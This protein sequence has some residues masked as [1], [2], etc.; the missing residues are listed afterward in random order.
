M[1]L[2]RRRFLHLAGCAAAIPAVS[3]IAMARTYPTRPVHLI[4]GFFAG[5]L[6][7]ILARLIAQSL[8]ERLG[9]QVIVDDRPG[10]GANIATESVVRATP[11]GYTLLLI[12]MANAVNASL[13]KDL[14]FNFIRDIMPVASISRSPGVMEVNPSFPAKTVP[15]FIAYAKANPGKID[16]ASG[17][18][19]SLPHVAGE[20]FNSMTGVE[21]VHVAYRGNFF[22][23]LLGG[24]VQV[25]FATVPASIGYIRAGK[26]RA[27]AVTSATRSEALPD[28]PTVSEFVPGYEASAWNGVGAPKNTPTEIIDTLNREINAGLADSAMQVRL[29]ELGSVPMPMSPAEFGKLIADETQKW[30]KVIKFAGIQPE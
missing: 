16:M 4:A 24:Q 12:S 11:D 6:S 14:N 9:Q 30:G 5:S 20:L 10:A 21:M 7:D 15:E 26:L 25:A 17:G 3:R 22:P 19:G 13:Y 1:K 18:I 8:S 2:P 28:I 29:A 23:D 27:L